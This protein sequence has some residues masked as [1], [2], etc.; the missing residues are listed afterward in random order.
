MKYPKCKLHVLYVM[1]A[2]KKMHWSTND[3]YIYTKILLF[4]SQRATNERDSV[5]K[6][7]H[8]NTPWI[9]VRGEVH[10]QLKRTTQYWQY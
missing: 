3:N 2:Q 5:T 4:L 8:L 7:F 9:E 10:D 1:I 6:G